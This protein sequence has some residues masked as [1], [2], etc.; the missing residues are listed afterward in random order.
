M[1]YTHSEQV[2]HHALELQ[3]VHSACDIP[4][5]HLQAYQL[6]LNCTVL[7]QQNRVG[8]LAT[9]DMVQ[10]LLQGVDA[11]EVSAG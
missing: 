4:L 8:S 1:Q 6:L 11:A 5:H 3:V 2:L 10:Y 9:S 7:V